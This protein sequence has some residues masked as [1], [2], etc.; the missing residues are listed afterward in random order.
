MGRSQY[1]ASLKK[2]E[3]I[4]FLKALVPDVNAAVGKASESGANDFKRSV[5]TVA[6]VLTGEY[7]SS[8][9]VQFMA[10]RSAEMGVPVF[11]VYANLLWFALEYG[12]VNMRSQP[13]VWPIYR[14]I[15]KKIKGKFTRE[16]RARVKGLG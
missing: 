3:A 10:D 5:Q 15:K 12:T 11:G 8:Y 16:I 9:K 14:L 1:K 6:P 7:R 2:A 13:H 4:G